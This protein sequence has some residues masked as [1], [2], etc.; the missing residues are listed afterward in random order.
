MF[1]NAAHKR[2]HHLSPEPCTVLYCTAYHTPIY[3]NTQK[4]SGLNN[5]PHSPTQSPNV[6]LPSS[7]FKTH[8]HNPSIFSQSPQKTPLTTHK[9]PIN[10][11]IIKTQTKKQPALTANRRDSH[12]PAFNVVAWPFAVPCQ[13]KRLGRAWKARLLDCFSWLSTWDLMKG[14]SL[15]TESRGGNGV[16]FVDLGW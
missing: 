16:C 15:E 3:H 2:H 5:P 6:L 10:I 11:N 4:P 13:L 8:I 9:P 7:T 1:L 12:V 14:V